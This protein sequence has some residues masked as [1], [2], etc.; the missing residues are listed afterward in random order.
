MDAKL[1]KQ[2]R[3]LTQ[4]GI[5]DCKKA[6]EATED[7]ID[8][9]VVWLKE[10]GLIKAAKKVDR[11]ASE[12]ITFAKIDDNCGVILEVNSETDFVAKNEA[13]IKVIDSIIEGLLKNKPNT[14]EKALQIKLANGLDIKT[15]L[16]E[17][18]ATIGEKIELRRF[19]I[20]PI[21]SD[22]TLTLYNHSNKRVSVL[23]D[24]QGNIDPESAYNVAMHVAAMA[25]QYISKEN[26]S[27]EFINSEL[28]VIKTQI[29]EDAKMKLKPANILEGIIQGK[30]TK[31]L[32]EVSLLDQIFVVDENFKVG[33]FLKKHNVVLK[34]M[35]RYE[36][37]EGIE[38]VVA[39]F[40]SE[41][42]AQLNGGK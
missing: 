27:Q 14:L 39:D 20:I 11:V 30:L 1:I 24:F 37:G 16:I 28:A 9:A 10:N 35:I 42:A 8:K 19:K 41:V 17:A 5:L 29:D 23:L 13:F 32:A 3:E 21:K 4:G 26:V 31:R 34:E 6:L 33:D 22:R 12:G 40:A 15:T 38:K 36:V 25:P 7:D 2:L 18:T